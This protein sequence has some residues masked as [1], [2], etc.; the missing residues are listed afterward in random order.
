MV[1]VEL[2]VSSQMLADFLTYLYPSEDDGCLAVRSDIFGKLLVSHLRGSDIPVT[3]RPG[4]HVVRLR[5]PINDTTRHFEKMWAYYTD[6]D[7]ASLNM[8]LAAVFELDFTG[9]YRKGEALGYQKKDIV[10]AFI[11]SRKLF[12]VDCFD[13]LHKRVYRKEQA[14]YEAIRQRLIRKTYYIDESIDYKGLG[15]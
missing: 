14:T 1:Y 13:A 7:E 15:K 2:K 10:D 4:D 9:Y 12:S 3:D 8:A 6:A 5:M 11:A